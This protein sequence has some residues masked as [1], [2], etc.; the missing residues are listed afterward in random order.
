MGIEFS[1]NIWYFK[2]NGQK[3]SFP[4]IR[5]CAIAY[6]TTI[7]GFTFFEAK[8]LFDSDVSKCSA[9]I[10]SV[11]RSHNNPSLDEALN[12]GDGVYWP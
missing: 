3:V 5:Q 11:L 1:N 9:I 8:T 2:Y 12:S 6:L 4:N 7:K 10:S